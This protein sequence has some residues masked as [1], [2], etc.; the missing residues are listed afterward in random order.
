MPSEQQPARLVEIAAQFRQLRAQVAALPGDAPE[1]ARLKDAAHAALDAGRLQQADDLL[2]QV[3]AAQDAELDRQ[4]REIERQQMERAATAAQR[5]GIA[6]TQLRYQ[7]AAEHFA[8][9]AKRVPAQHEEQ[10]LAYLDQEADALYRQGD[11]FGDNAALAD[12]IDRYRALLTQRPRDRVPLDWAKTQNQLGLALAVLGERESGTARLEEAVEAYRAALQ[13]RTREQ[14]P[15]P[16]GITQ[17][18]LGLALIGLGTREGSTARLEEAVDAFEGALEAFE[19][20]KA[21]YFVS[22]TRDALA[23]AR[24]RL[25]QARLAGGRPR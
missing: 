24:V 9:A 21:S 2:A 20:A 14:M 7:E 10:A 1:A 16:W 13:V 8:A 23:F 17:N 25:A 3:E 18:N 12:A 4:Q 22:G 6:L 15:L 11:E 19:A 5:A